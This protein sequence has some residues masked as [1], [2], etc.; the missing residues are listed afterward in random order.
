MAPSIQL[1]PCN[2]SQHAAFKIQHLSRSSIGKGMR[3]MFDAKR[4]ARKI[5]YELELT[6][7]TRFLTTK[8][9]DLFSQALSPS[10]TTSLPVALCQIHSHTS[11]A[12][13]TV[14]RL[15]A[16][17]PVVIF[18]KSSCC[19]CHTIKTLIS[20]FG[21]N[22]TVYELDELPH[23]QLMERELRALG[24]KPS[25]PA[26]FIGQELIG[27]P[28]EVMSLHLQCKLVPLLKKANAIWL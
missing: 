28:N 8:P 16:E 14:T 6:K 9:H 21:A 11:V 26:V 13:A 25:V 1:E 10:S 18:S 20:S 3:F 17:M 2:S 22:P 24:C 4:K 5:S 27:G 12:M 23:G 15:G 7:A 19:M